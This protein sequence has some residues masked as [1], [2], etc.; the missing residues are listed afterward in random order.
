MQETT[1]PETPLMNLAVCAKLSL[2]TDLA[3]SS[4]VWMTQSS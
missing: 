1:S 4:L 3:H 2:M